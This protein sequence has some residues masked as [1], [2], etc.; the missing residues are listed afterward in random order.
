MTTI[1]TIERIAGQRIMAGFDG[2]SLNADL[3]FLIDTIRVGGIIL[4]SRNIENRT[5]LRQLCAEARDYAG[6][7]GLPPLIIAV[8][9]EGGTVARLK[10]PEFTAF[11]GAPAIA[12]EADAVAFAAITSGELT[13][14]GINMDMAP[15][16]DVVPAGFDGVMVKR[17]FGTDPTRVAE[18]GG[19]IIDRL[20]EN[21]IMAVA[22]HFPGIGRTTLDSHLDRPDLGTSLAELATFD[23]IPFLEAIRR[24]VAGIMLSHIRY[25]DLDPVW[26]ASLSP[27]IARDLLRRQMGYGG[28]VLTDDMEMGAVNKHYDMP[29]MIR[30]VMAAE[31]DIALICHTRT[32]IET[33]YDTFCREMAD[34]PSLRESGENSAQRILSAKRAFPVPDRP[35][36]LQPRPG[37]VQWV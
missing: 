19:I 13:D 33:A 31:I 25:T 29:T 27:T 34:D 2:T 22:K 30:Q 21:G 11:A 24:R 23:F 37:E 35:R 16:M 1:Q 28:M 9:Q 15:V 5:Q 3:R 6:S 18:M 26:P 32:Q 8:D 17:V 12:A 4:F 10:A 14:V 20:Q 7:R 36:Q